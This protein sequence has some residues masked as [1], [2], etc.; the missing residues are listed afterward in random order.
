MFIYKTQKQQLLDVTDLVC[1]L[2]LGRK[3]MATPVILFSLPIGPNVMTFLT[4]WISQKLQ[5][6]ELLIGYSVNI[7]IYIYCKL[8][9]FNLK[10]FRQITDAL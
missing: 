4:H 2:I 3:T 7:D 10:C 1:N 9:R 5:L 6:Y 8:V